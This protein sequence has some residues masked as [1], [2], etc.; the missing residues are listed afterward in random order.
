MYLNATIFMIKWVQSSF[1]RPLAESG[2]GGL[3]GT[4]ALRPVFPLKVAGVPGPRRR[5][6]PGPPGSPEAGVSG[7]LVGTSALVRLRLILLASS[8]HAV[9]LGCAV[10]CAVGVCCGGAKGGRPRGS[11]QQS[12]MRKGR[13]AS[14]N[15]VKECRCGTLPVWSDGAQSPG[16]QGLLSLKASLSR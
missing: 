14:S 15:Q 9:T 10:G 13:R 4:W 2:G 6:W 12:E 11:A 16:G 7:D 8:V 1:L 3:W 5:A